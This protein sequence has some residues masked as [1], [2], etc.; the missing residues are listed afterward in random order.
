[1]R[2]ERRRL[3]GAHAE[4]DLAARHQQLVA[5][6]ERFSEVRLCARSGLHPGDGS[7]ACGRSPVAGVRLGGAVKHHQRWSDLPDRSRAGIVSAGLERR[8]CPSRRHTAPTRQSTCRPTARHTT[9][10]TVSTMTSAR[11]RPNC[12][13]PIPRAWVSS[14]QIHPMRGTRLRHDVD[15]R[16]CVRQREQRW[17]RHLPFMLRG[18]RLRAAVARP[19]CARRSS[20]D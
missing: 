3:A 14:I 5:Q 17:E 11:A 6:L 1:V 4:Q 12:S 19:R 16:C 18:A 13:Y 7:P 15:P 20:E 10:V 2:D 9:T 8:L